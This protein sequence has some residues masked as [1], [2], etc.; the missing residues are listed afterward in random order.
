MISR[1]HAAWIAADNLHEYREA[2]GVLTVSKVY[3]SDEIAGA[4]PH[5]YLTGNEKLADCWIVYVNRGCFGGVGA[6]TI[7]LIARATGRV[8]YF[9]SAMDGD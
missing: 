7:M 3:A 5:P 2:G 4:I 6:S 1:E 8:V 9:G